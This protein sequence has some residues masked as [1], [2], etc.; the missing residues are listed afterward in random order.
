MSSSWF[1]FDK[2]TWS[3]KKNSYVLMRR[4]NLQSITEMMNLKMSKFGC[5]L[6]KCLKSFEML[7]VIW[8]VWSDLENFKI[9]FSIIDKPNLVSVSSTNIVSLLN[10]YWIEF[11]FSYSYDASSVTAWFSAARHW[12]HFFLFFLWVT[13]FQHLPFGIVTM[14]FL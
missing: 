5:W 4:F 8:N 10:K 13:S 6:S 9:L 12:L 11:M 2:T 1:Y 14:K 3:G 7:E